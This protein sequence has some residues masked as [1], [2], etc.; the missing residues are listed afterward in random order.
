MADF[1]PVI[2]LILAHI[3]TA[4]R[5]GEGEAVAAVVDG[6]GVAIDDIVGVA[7]RQAAAQ[8]IE[9][10]AGVAGARDHERALDWDA[11]LVLDCR[12][13]PGRVRFAGMDGDG[14]A[15]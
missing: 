9:G 4:R 2:A 10:P 14:K 8:D 1:P 12:D 15:E 3:K 6:E 11:A 7:L 13:E 5:G